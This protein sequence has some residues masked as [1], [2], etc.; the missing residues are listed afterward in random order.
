[1]SEERKKKIQPLKNLMSHSHTAPSDIRREKENTAPPKSAVTQS[2][3]FLRCQKRE[4]KK[5]SP[6]K[7]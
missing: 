4:R 2:H 1:M 5:Y 6:S 7:I 3:I